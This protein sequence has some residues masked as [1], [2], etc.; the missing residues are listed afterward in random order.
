MKLSERQ[1]RSIISGVI[2]EAAKKPV[3]KKTPAPK[4]G[5]GGNALK[6]TRSDAVILL[7]AL[8]DYYNKDGA[9]ADPAQVARITKRLEKMFQGIAEEAY[10]DVDQELDGD[11]DPEVDPPGYGNSAAIQKRWNDDR[12]KK[13]YGP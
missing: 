2:S 7:A 9:A 13:V 4:G 5:P 1:L 11:D 12:L 8:D 6:L 3:K 10:E